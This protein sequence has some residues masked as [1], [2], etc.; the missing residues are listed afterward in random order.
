MTQSVVVQIGQCGNQIGCRFWDLALQEHAH[1]NKRGRYDDTTGTFFHNVDS[2]SWDGV[3][4]A[5]HGRIQ[6]L[7]A[8]AVLL[9][10]EEGV[11]SEILKGPLRELFDTTQL[12]T[13][14]S[15]AGNNWAVGHMTYGSSYRDKI[16]DQLRKAA[17]QCP[18]LQS[19]FLIHSMGGGTGSGL[20]TKVLRLLKDEFPEVCRIVIPVCPSVDDDVI[21]SP[22]NSMLAM[23]ELTENADCVLLVENQALVNILNVKHASHGG[24]DRKGNMVSAVDRLTGSEKPFDAMNDIVANMLLNL[25]SSARFEGSLNMDLNEIAM[26]LVPF[27]RLNYL[28]PSLSPVCTRVARG[29]EPT[30]RLDNLFSD[31]FTKSHQLIQ[32]DPKRSL[33]LGCALMLRGNVHMSDLRRNI[34]RLKSTVP[35]VSWNPEGWKTSICSVPAVGHSQSL[36]SLANTTAIKATFM[37]M[38]VRF[39]K[40]YRKKAHLHHYLQ[41][42]GMEESL[43]AEAVTSLDSLIEEYHHLDAG[44]GKL[45]PVARLKIAK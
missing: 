21:V 15:G 45:I 6:Q 41:V 19:F 38:R 8:R 28:I 37:E 13:G 43:F 32:A 36:L 24:Q 29:G 34:Q 33:Y 23:R 14:V 12:L 17:E 7:K 25:T 31:V 35:F 18:C 40:L 2:M 39:H 5:D 16:V 3:S 9:D 1:F 20:G 10:M 4:C 27:P 44:A 30:R 11:I 22:Y 26:N 42:E